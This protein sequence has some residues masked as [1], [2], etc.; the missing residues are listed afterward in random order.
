MSEQEGRR[1]ESGISDRRRRAILRALAISPVIL[2]VP[3]NLAQA[4]VIGS[5]GTSIC[6]NREGIS[7]AEDPE[8]VPTLIEKCKNMLGL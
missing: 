5:H 6:P 3:R 1:D 8:A 2:T 4:G 7:N